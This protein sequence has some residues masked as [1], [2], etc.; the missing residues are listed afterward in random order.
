VLDDPP[1]AVVQQYAAVG[2]PEDCAATIVRFI[3]AGVTD[4]I[5]NPL[6]PASWSISYIA[7]R[8]RP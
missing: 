7:T 1:Q 6:A 4:V 8:G 5:L 2:R 3:E